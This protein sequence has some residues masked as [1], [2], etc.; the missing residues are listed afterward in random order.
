MKE[1]ELHEPQSVEEATSMRSSLGE[2]SAFYAGGTELLLA[3]KSGLL[4]IE[5]IINVKGI[6]EFTSVTVSDDGSLIIGAA[7]THSLLEAS[8]IVREHFPLIANVES[9]VANL[10]VRNMG[11]IGGNLCFGEPHADPNPMLQLFDATVTLIGEHGKRE[12]PISALQTDAYETALQEDEILSDIRVPKWSPRTTGAYLKFGYHHRPTLGVGVAL[13]VDDNGI[14]HDV[15]IAIGSVS[16]FP[17]R[18]SDAERMLTGAKLDHVEEAAQEAGL[19][20]SKQVEAIDDLHGS[21]DYKRHLV[22]VF[23]PRAV[24]RAISGAEDGN[25]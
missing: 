17:L 20:A 23:V 10:R 16:P 22:S 4:N 19:I 13:T 18:I 15:R 21:A 25:S 2:S 7:A 1:L 24:N 8:P 14:I 11:T 6:P 3:L 5:H 12:L 9:R